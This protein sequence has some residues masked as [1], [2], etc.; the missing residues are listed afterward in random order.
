MNPNQR[1]F[2]LNGIILV[3]YM[4]LGIP[5]DTYI[6]MVTLGII[7][8]MNI[9]MFIYVFN[10]LERKIA[11]LD[12]EIHTMRYIDEKIRKIKTRNQTRKR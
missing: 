8:L 9:F 10:P 12:G 7:N 3:I 2:V 5:L 11:F 4:L 6:F 1:L